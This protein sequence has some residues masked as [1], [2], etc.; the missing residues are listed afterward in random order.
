MASSAR[1]P[2]RARRAAALDQAGVK[3]HLQVLGNGALQRI[4]GRGD[5]AYRL[6]SLRQQLEDTHARR[7]A[8][9][10]R[11]RGD[12]R[13]L[14]VCEPFH[15]VRWIALMSMRACGHMATVA[16]ARVRLCS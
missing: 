11:A 14:L 3:E 12:K 1:P 7:L 4:D 8:E 16:R 6:L 15:E 5:D 2:R 9:C 10:A 13:N